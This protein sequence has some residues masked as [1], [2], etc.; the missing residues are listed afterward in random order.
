MFGRGTVRLRATMCPDRIEAGRSRT[1]RRRESGFSLV[2]LL[3]TAAI[4]IVVLGALGSFLVSSTRAYQVNAARSEALQDSEAVLQLIRYETALAGFRGLDVDTF[5]RP[6]TLGGDESVLVA[7]SVGLDG[8]P[9][10]ALTVRY[11][12]DQYLDPSDGADTGERSIT[13]RVNRATQTLERVEVRP[14]GD[15]DDVDPLLVGNVASMQVLRL[16][17]PNRQR[18]VLEDYEDLLANQLAGLV[19]RVVFAD[20]RTWEFMIGLPN[21]QEFAVTGVGTP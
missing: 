12:E 20:E 7:R 4:F 6:F 15:P 11:F 17:G 5:Q 1:P 18:F 14:G 2:E 10:D 8:V 13:F 3:I 9:N 21:P 19:M 16:V